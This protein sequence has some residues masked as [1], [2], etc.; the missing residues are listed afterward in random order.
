MDTRT[1]RTVLAV[2]FLLLS[3]EGL[4]AQE[5]PEPRAFL[6]LSF[7]AGNP[8][9][10]LGTFFDQGFGAQLGGSWAMT[11][12]RRLRLRADLGGVVYGHERIAMC[13]P[14]TCRIGVDLTTTNNIFFAGVGP[15]YAFTSGAFE[16]YVFGTIGMSYFATISSLSGANDGADYFDTTNYSDVVMAWKVGGGARVRVRRGRRPISLDF[17]IERHENG[18]ANFLTEGDILDNPDGSVSLFPNRSEANLMTFR[19]GVSIGFR[20]N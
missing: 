4:A 13:F 18:I 17:G 19:F 2:G 14:T 1:W 6:G 9:G 10:D 11:E 8:V 5:Y 16:P 3:A 20:A 7:V 15:E 12:D